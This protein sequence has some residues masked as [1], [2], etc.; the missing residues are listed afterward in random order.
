MQLSPENYSAPRGNYDGPWRAAVLRSAL[1]L[2]SLFYE[3]G[4]AIAAAAT[5]SL[6]E[7]RGGNKNWDYRYSWV[8]DS[9]FTIDAFISLGLHE[10]THASLS[11]SLG[12]LRQNGPELQVFYTLDGDV[13]GQQRELAAR[14]YRDGPRCGTA[15]GRPLNCSSGTS[16]TCSTQ[17]P[18]SSQPGTCRT[19]KRLSRSPTWPTSAVTGLIEC[20]DSRG[21]W[22]ELDASLLADLATVPLGDA[23]PGLL[24]RLEERAG[25]LDDDIA[26]LLVEVGL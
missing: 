7:T 14:G 22:I 6:P 4:G 10:E 20:R 11:W 16:A 12:A 9:S 13:P 3:P 1:A 18:A 24:R 15:T 17:S 5:T 2:K 8:R 19:R 25:Q 23:L 26:L 21:E